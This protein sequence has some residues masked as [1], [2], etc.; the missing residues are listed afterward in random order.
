MRDGERM[1]TGV[2]NDDLIGSAT[3]CLI[4]FGHRALVPEWC[5]EN[6]SHEPSGEAGA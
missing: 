6:T 1:V 3:F 4:P 2:L 5:V